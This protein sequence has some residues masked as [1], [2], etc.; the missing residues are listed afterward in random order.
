M[1][2]IARH[3]AITRLLRGGAVRKQADLVRLLK[4]EGHAVTQSSVSRDL[5]EI[6]VLKAAEGY[7]LPGNEPA[8]T[9]ADF[10][11]LARFVRDLRVAGPSLTVLR[12]HA[13]AAQSVAL[14]I[15]QASWPDVVGTLSGDDTIFIATAGAR[16]QAALVKR[17][18]SLFNV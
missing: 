12:T 16:D 8:R 17:L 6:G 14:A 13:G 3:Q 2:A 9:A 15:D 5:R 11:G 1:H 7:V 10:T 18:R 4:A